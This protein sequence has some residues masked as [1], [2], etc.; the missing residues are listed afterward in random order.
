MLHFHQWNMKNRIETIRYEIMDNANQD[1]SLRTLP[2]AGN[3]IS[4]KGAQAQ[5]TDQ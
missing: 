2:F 3:N 1:L 4:R 5:R